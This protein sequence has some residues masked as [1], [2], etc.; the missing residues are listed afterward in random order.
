MDLVL[1][2]IWD[3]H[4]LTMAGVYVVL[5]GVIYAPA[6]LLL[7]H[8]TRPQARAQTVALSLMIALIPWLGVKLAV[9][10]Y[11]G[12]HA[13]AIAQHMPAKHPQLAEY[14][15]ARAAHDLRALNRWATFNRDPVDAGVIVKTQVA[16]AKLPSS[17]FKANLEKE[18]ATGYLSKARFE[19]SALS[20]INIS[21]NELGVDPALMDLASQVPGSR[22][23]AHQNDT[24]K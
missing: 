22:P 11:L 23:S 13:I 8:L 17:A 14:E 2:T 18:L 5:W 4:L 10:E 9:H 16:L 19:A 21:V 20:I 24:A 15:R 3:H 12:G 7:G 1:D 6:H